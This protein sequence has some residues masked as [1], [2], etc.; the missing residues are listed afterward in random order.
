MKKVIRWLCFGLLEW[1][2]PDMIVETAADIDWGGL[3]RLGIRYGI[4]DLDN[5]L[6][7]GGSDHVCVDIVASIRSATQSKLLLAVCI[8]TNMIVK[9]KKRQR[10][11]VKVALTIG[12]RCVVSL[13]FC[14]Q[15]PH[16]WGFCE[17][18]RQMDAMGYETAAVGDLLGTDILGGK[19]AG[20]AL[21]IWTRRPIGKQKRHIRVRRFFERAI[22]WALEL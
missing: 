18:M 9:T 10:R 1:F 6:V 11:A 13:G 20:V 3:Q 5:T 16:P 15:K 22:V 12:T 17:A 19:L 4:L 21:T 8:L 7:G 14:R 2:R